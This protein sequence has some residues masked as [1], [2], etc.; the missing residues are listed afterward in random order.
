MHTIFCHLFSVNIK[1]LV[2]WWEES[3]ANQTQEEMGASEG[4]TKRERGTVCQKIQNTHWIE[5]GFHVNAFES[6][7]QLKNLLQGLSLLEEHEDLLQKLRVQK[8]EEY[9]IDKIKMDTEV[10]VN[11]IIMRITL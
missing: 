8:A 2:W 6:T 4:G 9:N 1:E 3:V 11:L 5:T 10:Q 7:L